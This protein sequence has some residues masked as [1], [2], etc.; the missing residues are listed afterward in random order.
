VLKFSFA[1]AGLESVI[2]NLATLKDSNTV[3]QAANFNQ[4]DWWVVVANAATEFAGGDRM[5]FK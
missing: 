1:V 2:Q 4:A 3:L 5:G